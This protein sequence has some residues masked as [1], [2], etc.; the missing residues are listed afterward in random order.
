M[1]LKIK[2]NC[3]R[4]NKSFFSLLGNKQYGEFIFIF[5]Y[6]E[7]ATIPEKI[8]K[9]MRSI[10]KQLGRDKEFTISVVLKSRLK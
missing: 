8:Q 1:S 2:F 7:E 9:K 3:L 5:L 6:I 4:T 10:A